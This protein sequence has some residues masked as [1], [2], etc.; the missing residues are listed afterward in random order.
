MDGESEESGGDG[1]GQ[2]DDEYAC[3]GGEGDEEDAW[4]V[5]EF[6]REGREEKAREEAGEDCA[7]ENEPCETGKEV[8]CG[9]DEENKGEIVNKAEEEEGEVD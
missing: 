6:M 7:N 3:G 4:S 5:R 2:G 1:R 9:C 8:F